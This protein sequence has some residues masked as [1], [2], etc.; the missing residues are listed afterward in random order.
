MTCVIFKV[1]LSKCIFC[2]TYDMPPMFDIF[3]IPVP[4]LVVPPFHENK[5]NWSSIMTKKKSFRD[6]IEKI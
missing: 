6:Q 1:Q 2:E 4:L 5:M 3:F